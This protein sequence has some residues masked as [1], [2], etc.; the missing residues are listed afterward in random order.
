MLIRKTKKARPN[1][2][3][4]RIYVINGKT[5]DN[6]EKISERSGIPEY[7]LMTAC[8]NTGLFFWTP[9]AAK[10]RRRTLNQLIEKQKQKIE[11]TQTGENIRKMAFELRLMPDTLFSICDDTGLFPIK[12]PTKVVS[13][14]GV[15]YA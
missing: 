14:H 6:L 8:E 15:D 5:L 9:N 7:I 10:P 11:A 4:E 2:L 13:A 1:D 3:P 12:A